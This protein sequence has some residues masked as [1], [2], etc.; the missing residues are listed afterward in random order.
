M[1]DTRGHLPAGRLERHSLALGLLV[2]A[3]AAL[4]VALAAVAVRGFPFSERWPV[5]AIVPADGPPLKEGNE[6][7]VGGA[8]FGQVRRVEPRFDG[9]HV[10]MEIDEGPVGSDARVRVRVRGLSAEPYVELERGDPSRPLPPEATIPRR[11]TTANTELVD[12]LDVFDPPARRSLRRVAPALG[13]GLLG[14]GDDLNATLADLEPALRGATPLLRAVS[15]RPGSLRTALFDARRLLRALAP[16][17]SRELE[18]L[19]AAAA[20]TLETVA[21]R[22]REVERSLELLAPV[23]AEA[24]RT[25]P[26]ADALLLEA[27]AALVELRPGVRGLRD[28][29]PE[30]NRLL[31]RDSG[32]RSAARLARSAEPVLARTR[33]LLV[34]L[35]PSTDALVALLRPLDSL[36][37][38]LARY[39]DEIRLAAERGRRVTEE[40]SPQGRA[41]GRRTVRTVPVFT[42]NRPREPY[43]A[44]GESLRQRR[45]CRG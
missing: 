11:Q 2:L 18:A 32:L 26:I 37:G 36:V 31:R 24:A 16:P 10:R 29:L 45:A 22:A 39:D 43:P 44:P 21:A 7:R 42:C 17:G 20:T 38:E 34:E 8:R 13:P 40:R 12:V 6:V 27:R 15:P 1:N 3:G 33:P 25:L 41:S 30:V 28:S 9:A 23:E 5:A 19:R 14:R 4:L 35:R